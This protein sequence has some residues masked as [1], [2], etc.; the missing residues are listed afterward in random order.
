[1]RSDVVETSIVGAD[2][3]KPLMSFSPLSSQ[4]ETID[5]EMCFLSSFFRWRWYDDTQWLQEA[6]SRARTDTQVKMQAN[7]L[8][9]VRANLPRFIKYKKDLGL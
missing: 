4:V 7:R 3:S 5:T 6:K 2:K 1:M 9:E 8:R